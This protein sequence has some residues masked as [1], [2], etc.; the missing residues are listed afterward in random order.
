LCAA[1]ATPLETRSLGRGQLEVTY[2]FYGQRFISIVDAATLQVIDAG[3]C[4]SGSDSLVTLESLPSVIKEAIET[5]RLVITRRDR[6]DPL[7]GDYD[8]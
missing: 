8:D 3:V 4:L 7:Y 2:R 5:R 6:S 1:G